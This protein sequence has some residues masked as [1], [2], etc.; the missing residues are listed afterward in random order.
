MALILDRAVL[1][2]VPFTGG[3]WCH[4]AFQE[5]GIL[6]GVLHS[7]SNYPHPAAAE[8]RAIF[9]EDRTIACI[10]RHPVTWLRSYWASAWLAG[11]RGV[12]R[13][14]IGPS[15][16]REFTACEAP[17]FVGFIDRY[18]QT[19][20]GAVGRFMTRYTTGASFVGRYRTL[21]DDV[22][23]F[24]RRAGEL[25]TRARLVAVPPVNITRGRIPAWVETLPA[26]LARAVC[27]AE[28]DLLA[29]Y[30]PEDLA[31]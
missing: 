20:P 15:P 18:L 3:T 8:V 2:H 13:L 14:R 19:C 12:E 7:G 25:V 28:H 4:A 30:Y 17:T 22:Y 26:E 16:W 31:A 27:E 23:K 10:V 24:L 21:I 5:L 11:G 29:T 9:G 6:R 1:L